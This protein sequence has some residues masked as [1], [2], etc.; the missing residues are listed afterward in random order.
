MKAIETRPLEFP[1]QRRVETCAFRAVPQE[2]ST[3]DVAV[4]ELVRQMT[5]FD[6]EMC[7]VTRAAC[8]ACCQSPWPCTNELNPVIGSLICESASRVMQHPGR[9]LHEA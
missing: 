2:L 4:C 7:H 3:Q 6:K 8:E 1:G 9:D 5:G